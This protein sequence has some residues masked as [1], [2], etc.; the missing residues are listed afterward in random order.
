MPASAAELTAQYGCSWLAQCRDLHEAC[1]QRASLKTVFAIGSILQVQDISNADCM[2]RR[3]LTF[4]AE[5]DCDTLRL[6]ELSPTANVLPYAALSHRWGAHEPLVLTRASLAAWRADGRKLADL[7]RTFRD[8][9]AATRAL[10]LSSL[11]IDSLCI[12][13]DDAEDW[14]AEAPRMSVVYGN[15]ACGI[16]AM[17]AHDSNGGLFTGKA[18]VG[19]STTTSHSTGLLDARAWVM[20]ERML[21]PR[22]LIY[23]GDQIEWECREATAT[24]DRTTFATT[25][26]LQG[27]SPDSL[28]PKSLYMFL[29]DWHPPQMKGTELLEY[30]DLEPGLIGDRADYEPFLKIWWRFVELYTACRL[31]RGSDKFLALN[32]IGS[33]VQSNTR[34]RSTWG[35]WS[36]ADFLVNELTWSVDP[37]GT[38]G[39]RPSRFR[40]PFWS[41]ASLDGGPVVNE[42]YRRLPSRPQMMLKPQVRVPVNT[43]FDQEL[44]MVAWTHENYSMEVKGDLREGELTVSD[45]S[46]VTQRCDMRLDGTGRW[47]EE[48]E[49]AFRPDIRLKPGTH[50]VSCLSMLHYERDVLG[51]ECYLDVHL[52]MQPYVPDNDRIMRRIGCLETTY[53]Q[54]RNQEDIDADLWWKYVQL[55]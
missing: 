2:P 41:W 24:Q 6:V 22:T 53:K 32:G 46:G 49:H 8:A 7:P 4:P 51:G 43:S 45:G 25:P 39:S 55:R 37:A 50:K 54:K 14:K 12:V 20:Q 40:A 5:G 21:A 11:W 17:D 48:E 44:P 34:L 9:V 16:M 30:V 13:Q 29:N 42:Y 47:S 36:W 3:L 1:H 18:V 27:S 23:T 38:A 33:K 35:L 52:V 15:A 10:G 19:A 28:S 26:G 31:T